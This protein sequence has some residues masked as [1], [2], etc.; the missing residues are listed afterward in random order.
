M[1]VYGEGHSRPVQPH[2]IGDPRPPTSCCP[3]DKRGF[4][5]RPR[6]RSDCS[7]AATDLVGMACGT[8]LCRPSPTEYPKHG[9]IPWLRCRKGTSA[10]PSMGEVIPDS[11]A[12]SQAQYRG[13][14]ERAHARSCGAT[15]RRSRSTA[16][17]TSSIAY[18]AAAAGLSVPPTSAGIRW[19]CLDCQRA[20]GTAVYGEARRP[21][22]TLFSALCR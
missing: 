22:S 21:A 2:S 7:P 19:P 14:R 9:S 12:A 6:R 10:R 4:S 18:M 5:S 11:P 13:L 1:V 8:G 15:G 20:A 3:G 17:S 16:C